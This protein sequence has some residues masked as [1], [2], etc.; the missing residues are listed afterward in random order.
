LGDSRLPGGVESAWGAGLEGGAVGEGLWR[1][2]AGREVPGAEG[3][4]PGARG[5]QAARDC[6][7]P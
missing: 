6:V 7:H 3:E 5:R 2:Q 1:E 4:V